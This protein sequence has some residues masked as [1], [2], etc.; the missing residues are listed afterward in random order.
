MTLKPPSHRPSWGGIACY[1]QLTASSHSDCHFCFKRALMCFLKSLRGMRIFVTIFNKNGPALAV[2]SICLLITPDAH[3]TG[4]PVKYN[5]S[6]CTDQQ[7]YSSILRTITRTRQMPSLMALWSMALPL[8]AS[9]L[10]PV[11]RFDIH[12][13]YVRK[14]PVT[15]G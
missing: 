13:G 6:Y 12:P 5:A 15:W 1:L 9:C 11:P 8:T 7:R 2:H 10:S 3:M 4:D 14:L